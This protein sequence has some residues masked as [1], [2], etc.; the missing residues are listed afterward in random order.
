[1]AAMD[2]CIHFP[3]TKGTTPPLLALFDRRQ[4]PAGN[5]MNLARLVVY[6]LRISG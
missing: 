6:V 1:M 4:Q 5:A 3:N 2:T